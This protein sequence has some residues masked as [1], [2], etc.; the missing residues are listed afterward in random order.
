MVYWRNGVSMQVNALMVGLLLGGLGCSKNKLGLDAGADAPPTVRIL[1][2]DGD[3]HFYV[4][5]KVAL[6]VSVT[7]DID[8]IGALTVAWTSDVDGALDVPMAEGGDGRLSGA[9][10]LD[11]AEHLLRVEVTDSA[12]NTAQ[13]QVVIN[14][15]P[16]NSPPVCEI[17][18][19]D[20][21]AIG[22]PGDMVTF[23]AEITDPDVAPNLLRAEWASTLQGPLGGSAVSSDGRSVLPVEDLVPG[24]HTIQLLVRDE[25]DGICTDLI[26]YRVGQG[27]QLEIFSPTDGTVVDEGT[28]VAFSGIATD[29]IDASRDLRIQWRSDADGL[30]NDIPADTD[31]TMEF[32]ID[33]LSRGHHT[34]TLFAINTEGMSNDET[35]TLTINGVPSQPE[36]EIVPGDPTSA[37]GLVAAI[38]VGSVDPDGDAV[39]YRYTWA[40]N[41]V[42]VF[43]GEAASVASTATV[44]GDIWRLTVTPS[45]GLSDGTPAEDEV[46]I[47]NDPPNLSTVSL[48]PEMADTTTDFECT[49]TADADH[50]GDTVTLIYAWFVGGD[51]MPVTTAFLDHD[52]TGRGD[53]VYCEVTPHDG[54]TSGEAIRSNIVTID[55][56]APRVLAAFIDPDDVRAGDRPACIYFGYS[57]PDGDADASVVTWFVNGVLSS[58]GSFG[59]GDYVRGDILMCTVTPS[60]GSLD[61]SPIS[62]SITVQNTPPSFSWVEMSPIPASISDTIHCS[63]WGFSD[64]DGDDDHSTISWDINGGVAGISS[65]LSWG[66]VGGD[67]V[68]CTAVPND[69]FDDGLAITRTQTIGDT[70]PSIASVSISPPE[71]TVDDAL[72]CTYTG[73]DDPDGDPDMSSFRWLVEG[74]VV[75]GGSSGTLYSGFSSTDEV[76]CQVTPFDGSTEGEMLWASVEIANTAPEVTS[77][78]LSPDPLHTDDRVTALLTAFDGDGDLVDYSYQWQ[79]NGVDAGLD[80]RSLEGDVWFDRGDEVEVIVY[81]ND[82]HVFGEPVI[83]GPVIVANSGPTGHSISISPTLPD[84]FD[85]ALVCG[86]EL[87][88]VDPDGDPVSY[89]FDWYRDGVLHTGAT[90]T[91]LPGDT[92][93]AGVPLEG[94]YWRCE[95]KA[96]DGDALGPGVSQSVFIAGWL[97]RVSEEPAISCNHILEVN[98]GASDGLYYLAPVGDTVE[99]HCDMSTDGGGWTLVAFAPMNHS[100]PDEFFDGGAFDAALCPLMG[101]FCRL[102]DEE[103]NAILGRG[104]STDDRFRLVSLGTPAHQRYYWDTPH[105]F[106]SLSFSGPGP[107]WAAAVEYGGPHSVGC[108]LAEGRGVGHNP[109]SPACSASGTF[110]SGV[111][112]RVFWATSDRAFVGGATDST[113]AWYAK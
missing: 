7:D 33:D 69:G 84:A 107:W 6:V 56:S 57:D 22:N 55:N 104:S 91:D 66:F 48:S 67:T 90:T 61:G 15:G 39:S 26:I 54:F 88:A 81:P 20:D 38:N 85:D 77:G 87:E 29:S 111:S 45:D 8:S 71:P 105:D 30:L 89:V 98:P 25:R 40:Q 43:D 46:I 80:S 9:V 73:W 35:I 72:V 63:A 64:P 82:G 58:T 19:P 112:D 94:E 75:S 34:I 52:W 44:K 18:F 14:V 110:G 103:I 59:D 68:S 42:V 50:D 16:P 95:V 93:E 86:V 99:A 108:S 41:G 10:R 4:D 96:T 109:S 53:N 47:A 70:P 12:G 100:A 65:S 36:V 5:T 27:P 37:N 74:M 1:S 3:A 51:L 97:G 102:S 13:D 113:F 2:P 24:T 49:A 76:I 83:I 17:V 11:E 32:Q 21:G 79:V 101:V 23:T 106:S 78:V 60:D 92:I 28:S 62:A 31:G